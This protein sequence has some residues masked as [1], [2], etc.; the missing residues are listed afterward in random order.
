MEQERLQELREMRQREDAAQELR[1]LDRRREI[2]LRWKD[3]SPQE[4]LNFYYDVKKLKWL[5]KKKGIKGYST[6]KRDTLIELLKDK[7]TDDDF[8]IR[9]E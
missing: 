5:C 1:D 9:C 8:P 2:Q 6:K 7:V 4:K 3:S